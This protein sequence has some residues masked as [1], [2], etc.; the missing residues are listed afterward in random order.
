M[1]LDKLKTLFAVFHANKSIICIV[2]PN[3]IFGHKNVF[4]VN[5]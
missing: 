3:L 4:L 1:S 2:Q 5:Y